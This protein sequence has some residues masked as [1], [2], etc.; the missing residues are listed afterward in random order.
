[1]NYFQ[2]LCANAYVD[3]V[4]Q[5][6]TFGRQVFFAV[7]VYKKISR[8]FT[9]ENYALISRHHAASRIFRT[10]FNQFNSIVFFHIYLRMVL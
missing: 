3:F 2:I 7:K 6:H 8:S 1:M 4:I 5:F 9:A 10:V